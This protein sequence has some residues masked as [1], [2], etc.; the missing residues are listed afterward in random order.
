MKYSIVVPAFNEHESLPELHKEI[1]AAMTGEFELVL[2]DD[3]ST[4]GT[5]QVIRELAAADSRII[6]V[7]LRRNREPLGSQEPFGSNF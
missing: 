6:P 7:I 1:V 3:G 5:D 2:V 4:D